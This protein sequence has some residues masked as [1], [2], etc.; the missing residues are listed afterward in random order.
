MASFSSPWQLSLVINRKGEYRARLDIYQPMHFIIDELPVCIEPEFP[1]G[2]EESIAADIAE[3][4]KTPY[5]TYQKPTY[6]ATA[7]AHENNKVVA[8]ANNAWYGEHPYD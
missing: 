8:K 3:K 2:L 6:P 7:A 1:A 5:T 4:V